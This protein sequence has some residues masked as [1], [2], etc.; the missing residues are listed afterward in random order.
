MAH[1]SLERGTES[2]LLSGG[3]SLSSR[4]EGSQQAIFLR[5]S[6]ND[7]AT[8]ATAPET[9]DSRKRRRVLPAMSTHDKYAMPTTVDRTA[10]DRDRIGVLRVTSSLMDEDSDAERAGGESAAASPLGP[11]ELALPGLGL[12][13]RS[14]GVEYIFR[15]P[16]RNSGQEEPSAQTTVVR[17]NASVTGA[18]DD[19]SLPDDAL[20]ADAGAG[21]GDGGAGGRPAH[22]LTLV[23]SSDAFLSVYDS[24][25]AGRRAAA[26]ARTASTETADADM[27]FSVKSLLKSVAGRLAVPACDG[28]S[29]DVDDLPSPSAGEGGRGDSVGAEDAPVRG[30]R[31]PPLNLRRAR[32][33]D[34]HA[35][36]DL[37]ER[38]R[39]CDQLRQELEES[40]SQ[41]R[42]LR[43]KKSKGRAAANAA[44]ARADSLSCQLRESR[45]EAEELRQKL[46]R[47]ADEASAARTRLKRL[48]DEVKRF[49][50]DNV[51]RAEEREA[52]RRE[53]GRMRDALREIRRLE[54]VRAEQARRT[55]SE[56]GEAR[57]ALRKA[58][59]AA[60]VAEAVLCSL[61]SS[62]AA[63]PDGNDR[64]LV[65]RPQSGKNGGAP[66]GKWDVEWQEQEGGIEVAVAGGPAAAAPSLDRIN[67][68]VLGA[69]DAVAGVNRLRLTA[70]PRRRSPVSPSR[71]L[72]SARDDPA[73][74]DDK[75]NRPRTNAR[76]TACALCCHPPRPNGGLEHCPCGRAECHKWAHAS[77]LSNRRSGSVSH[78]GTPGPAIP[79]IL[80]REIGEWDD[81]HE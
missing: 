29:W 81:S 37:S 36:A 6:E 22:R 76:E 17:R 71:K 75:E 25:A 57:A 10:G 44:S 39:E 62:A 35:Q 19:A 72:S 9:R 15:T 42:A 27:D 28:G 40:R 51:K 78:P 53:A 2:S 61:R 64:S 43:R 63:A 73:H 50:R 60:T 70:V 65:A 23:E 56:L 7:D 31:M 34:A 5:E 48:E 11:G 12:G 77:C 67:A 20:V 46:R 69:A 80:C 32:T 79:A 45:S 18:A 49:E 47:S 1:E 30:W 21:G 14:P 4:S 74:S 24:I 13:G 54:G 59:Q 66:G 38:T 68:L 26:D 55:K 3:S 52:A 58:G 33:R 16:T 8:M 41:I